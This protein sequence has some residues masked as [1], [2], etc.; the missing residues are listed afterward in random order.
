MHHND[1]HETTI[2][3]APHCIPARK[4]RRKSEKENYLPYQDR[5]KHEPKQP[6]GSPGRSLKTKTV[7]CITIVQMRPHFILPLGNHD[8]QVRKGTMDSLKMKQNNPN[9]KRNDEVTGPLRDW[10]SEHHHKPKKERNLPM[11]LR[12]AQELK[13]V[14]HNKE[15]KE[16]PHIAA[17]TQSP[18]THG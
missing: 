5:I 4:S 8:N 14:T 12:I 10:N 2:N 11:K 7:E 1:H 3:K 17:A 15:P 18:D 16:L 9:L 13:I 6:S